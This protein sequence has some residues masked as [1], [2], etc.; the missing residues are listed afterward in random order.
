MPEIGFLGRGRALG[1]GRPRRA[2]GSLLEAEEAHVDRLVGRGAGPCVGHGRGRR[3][4]RPGRGGGR[5][6]PATGRPRP[7]GRGTDPARGPEAIATVRS[8]SGAGD[9]LGRAGPSPSRRSGRPRH[10]GPGLVPLA[11]EVAPGRLRRGEI[12]LDLDRRLGV[13]EAHAEHGQAE[14]VVAGR[15]FERGLDIGGDRGAAVAERP[16]NAPRRDKALRQLTP[17]PAD[18]GCAPSRPS[19][20]PRTNRDESATRYWTTARAWIRL[21]SPVRYSPAPCSSPV[22]WRPRHRPEPRPDGPASVSTRQTRSSRGQGELRCSPG[23]QGVGAGPA[24]IAG[25]PPIPP[26]RPTRGPRPRRRPRAG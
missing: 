20:A 4:G 5:S 1:F 14:A 11:F 12:G 24:R 22:S 21:R 18:S 26:A 15:P 10:R 23:P 6:G 17:P 16:V 13:G 25:P 9:L 3:G 19:A 8:A 2:A 7:A